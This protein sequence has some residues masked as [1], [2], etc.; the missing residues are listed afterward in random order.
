MVAI[1]V[2]DTFLSPIALLN[3]SG[4]GYAMLLFYSVVILFSRLWRIENFPLPLDNPQFM[5]IGFGS[6][7]NV[8][9]LFSIHHSLGC[10]LFDL[11]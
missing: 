11:N 6:D 1:V 7:N 10:F 3:G 2:V 8:P 4:S 9:F 5:I